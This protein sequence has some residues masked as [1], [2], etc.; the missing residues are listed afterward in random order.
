MVP[1]SM[2]RTTRFP[3]T[4]LSFVLEGCQDLVGDVE[5]GGDALD[6]VVVLEGFHELED[7]PRV[8][9]REPHRRP[10]DAGDLGVLDRDA[11]LLEGLADGR[12]TPGGPS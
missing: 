2:P 11:G 9:L 5:V 12:E 6:V 8:V 3:S 1:G 4:T 7:L 10:R